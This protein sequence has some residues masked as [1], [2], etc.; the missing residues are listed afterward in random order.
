MTKFVKFLCITAV[1]AGC[2][3][4]GFILRSCSAVHSGAYYEKEIVRDSNEKNGGDTADVSRAASYENEEEPDKE[5]L[6]GAAENSPT[7]AYYA[8]FYADGVLVSKIPLIN[9][10]LT[11][12]EPD[13]PEKRGYTGKWAQYALAADENAIIKAE[14][15]LIYYTIEYFN[16]P[17]ETAAG[18]P[19]TYTVETP[20][21]T[22]CN[23]T[24]C[25]F[26][27]CGWY[28][29]EAYT[30]KIE[31]IKRNSTGN[32]EAY[33]R[34]RLEE[35]TIEYETEG[36]ENPAGNPAV[37]TLL[38]ET[39][40]LLPAVRKNYTF[41]G[42]FANGQEIGEIPAGSAG[43]LV[44]TA[45]WNAEEA[46][47]SAVKGGTLRE[48]AVYFIFGAD[49][50]SLPVAQQIVYAEGC[51]G[52]VFRANAADAQSEAENG[53]PI[54]TTERIEPTEAIEALS[55]SNLSDGDNLFYLLVQREE[56]ETTRTYTL[57]VYKQYYVTVSYYCGKTLLRQEQ[58]LAGETFLPS[59]R[60]EDG[61]TLLG[62]VYLSGEHKGEKIAA[63]EEITLTEDTSLCAVTE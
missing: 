54:E 20:D 29:D 40:T 6:N 19:Q 35:Y 33:A 61:V 3:L 26:L 13:V 9:G 2:A 25:G 1:T 8:E 23:A 58:A 34:W 15:S 16:V 45:K 39:I 44:L 17:G 57:H 42:W 30:Q 52:T 49:E 41:I 37:Y 53:E 60:L 62:W 22:F 48:N 56:S 27:F 14:Y 50:T 12:E 51:Y 5:D 55:A 31:G 46:Y 47:V 18:N 4:S 36:G 10:Q 24:R 59:C 21:F 11:K 63:G 32:L 7:R 43:N 38:S 28:K